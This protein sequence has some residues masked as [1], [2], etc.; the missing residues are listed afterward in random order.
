MDVDAAAGI[1]TGVAAVETTAAVAAVITTTG[2][3]A[4]LTEPALTMVMQ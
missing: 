3:E 2:A 4:G 1:I